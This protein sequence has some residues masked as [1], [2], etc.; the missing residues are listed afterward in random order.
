[1]DSEESAKPK[2][3]LINE[4]RESEKNKSYGFNRI[5]WVMEKLMKTLNKSYGF[6]RICWS[7]KKLVK[8]LIRKN[9]WKH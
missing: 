5:C 1:M 9:S 6:R 4:T 3:T 7:K 2:K 8:S